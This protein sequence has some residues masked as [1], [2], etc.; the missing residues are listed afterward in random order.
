MVAGKDPPVLLFP[1]DREDACQLCLWVVELRAEAARG[2]ASGYRCRRPRSNRSSGGPTDRPGVIAVR[3]GRR[4]RLALSGGD[5]SPEDCAS[6]W[7]PKSRKNL[8]AQT[9]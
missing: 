6:G 8:D 7:H 9:K 5:P 4:A 2:G 1:R 3:F